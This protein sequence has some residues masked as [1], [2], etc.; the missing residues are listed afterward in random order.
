MLS[1]T[2]KKVIRKMFASLLHS[3]LIGTSNLSGFYVLEVYLTSLWVD[4]KKISL[5][6]YR[7]LLRL[8][9]KYLENY[10]YQ[11]DIMSFKGGLV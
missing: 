3:N 11:N 2:N 7:M 4:E 10:G 5:R 8:A 1:S 9:S 6:H